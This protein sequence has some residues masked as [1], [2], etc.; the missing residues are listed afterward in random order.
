MNAFR[1]TLWQATITQQ[2]SVQIAQKIGDAHEKNPYAL[3]GIE[4]FSRVRY[5]N[6]SLAD[7][8]VDLLNNRIGRQIGQDA[9]SSCMKDIAIAT[10]NYY[11]E[12][13]LWVAVKQDNGHYAIIQEKLSVDQ[14]KTALDRLNVLD[15]NGYAP[16]NKKK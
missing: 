8:A 15:S 5:T 1:H 4:D 3:D 14:Y 7:E 16:E 2:F 12:N 11:H 9:N 13:G 10:L 6:L